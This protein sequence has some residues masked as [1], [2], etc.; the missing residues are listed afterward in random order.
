DGAHDRRDAVFTRH[1]GG[2]RPRAAAVHHDRDGPLE[3]RGPGRVRVW[4]NEHVARAELA[5]LRGITD[6][7]RGSVRHAGAARCPAQQRVASNPAPRQELRV[8]QRRSCE[9]GAPLL[10]AYHESAQLG[11]QLWWRRPRP[12]YA[13]KLTQLEVEYLFGGIENAGGNQ[14]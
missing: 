13:F 10:A 3:E 5:E 11:S 4:R 14:A 2:V 9:R 7:A 1:D 6:D 8:H 12:I